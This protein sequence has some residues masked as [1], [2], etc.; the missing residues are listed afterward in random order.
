MPFV[1]TDLYMD[2]ADMDCGPRTI[3]YYNLSVAFSFAEIKVC[4]QS[5]W[6][7]FKT[8]WENVL[9]SIFLSFLYEEFPLYACTPPKQKASRAPKDLYMYS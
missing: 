1:Q 7:I 8:Q 6:K 5:N 4:P 2:H 9:L 3:M